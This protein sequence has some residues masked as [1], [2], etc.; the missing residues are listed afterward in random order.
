MANMAIG[1]TQ[2]RKVSSAMSVWTETGRQVA[3]CCSYYSS[4]RHCFFSFYK[5]NTHTH[6][7]RSE[8]QS[9]SP[10]PKCVLSIQSKPAKAPFKA[11]QGA[12]LVF[13]PQWW[14]DVG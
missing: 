11:V 10:N 2:G 7:T 13:H 4:Q 8:S 6:P 3:I 5:P 12:L 14:E 9:A 1:S